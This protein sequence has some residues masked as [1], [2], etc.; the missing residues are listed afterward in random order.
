MKKDSI[1]SSKREA[2]LVLGLFFLAVFI[3]AIVIVVEKVNNKPSSSATPVSL[4]IV[5][6]EHSLDRYSQEVSIFTVETPTGKLYTLPVVLTKYA[7]EYHEGDFIPA[8]VSDNSGLPV[9]E[10]DIRT[11][12]EALRGTSS[13]RN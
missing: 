6:V 1:L 9:Y 3:S 5:S 10:V 4:E 11:L 8:L 13:E 2:S 12:R 7:R